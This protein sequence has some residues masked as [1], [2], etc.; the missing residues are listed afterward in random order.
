MRIMYHVMSRGRIDSGA[1]GCGE[2]R[3]LGG[4]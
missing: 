3:L 2:W 1:L 4:A